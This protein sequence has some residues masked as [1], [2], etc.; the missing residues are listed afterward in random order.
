MHHMKNKKSK[1]THNMKKNNLNTLQ[2]YISKNGYRN[3]KQNI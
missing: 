3:S 2:W 1:L